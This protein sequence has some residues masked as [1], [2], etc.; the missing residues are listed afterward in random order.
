MA[1]F[2]YDMAA[3]IYDMAAFIYDMAAFIYDMASTPAMS[4]ECE[5]IF[6]SAKLLLSDQ[7]AR[8]T[9]M[10]I[11]AYE[12]LR[13]WLL[14]GT[15]NDPLARILPQY[16]KDTVTKEKQDKEDDTD[17]RLQDEDDEDDNGD[18]GFTGQYELV[19]HSDSENAQI[20]LLYNLI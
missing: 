13:H 18:K 17:E 20:E 9:P 10:L 15:I 1:A 8:M 7:R 19:E 5:R 4:A 11:E 12:C 14:A 6:S 16:D 2:I 3:F